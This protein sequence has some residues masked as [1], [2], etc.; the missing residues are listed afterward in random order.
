MNE[1]DKAILLLV[2]NGYRVE[3]VQTHLTHT[4][5]VNQLIHEMF[6]I[7]KQSVDTLPLTDRTRKCL[8]DEGICLIIDLVYKTE[9][10]LHYS[11]NLGRKSLNEIKEALNCHGL[12]L[13]TIP[14]EVDYDCSSS[15]TSSS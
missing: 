1:I 13:K 5:T 8:K 14:K 2:Q 6:D 9:T 12:H 10:E 7:L 4:V 11:P 3:K 15:T